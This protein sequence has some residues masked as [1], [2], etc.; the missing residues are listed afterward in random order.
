VTQS[1]LT[2][3]AGR[4]TEPAAAQDFHA[5]VDAHL[6]E[7]SRLAFMLSGD[8]DAAD[9]LAAD[10]LLAAWRQWDRV[11]SADSRLAYVRGIVVNLASSRVRRLVRE[12]SR[13][14]L[15]R[16]DAR[17]AVTR[18]PD[19]PAIVDL[20]EA[21]ARLPKGQRACLVLRH[22]LGLSEVETAAALGISVGTVKSQTSKG[23]AQLR[24]RIGAGDGSPI[25][26]EPGR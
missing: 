3:G 5:F 22:G 24:R 26:I 23:A 8:R 19:T 17:L 20:R 10:A 18:G 2:S 15:L 25:H 16:S 4:A 6:S 9:D 21:L 11:S 13:L 7:L 14:V 12:R 1:P